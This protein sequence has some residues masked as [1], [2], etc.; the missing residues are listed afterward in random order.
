MNE[1]TDRI[2]FDPSA[3]TEQQLDGL[4]CVVCADA[5]AAGSRSV[6]AGE[7]LGAQVFACSSHVADPRDVD[8]AVSAAALDRRAVID[9]LSRVIAAL[10]GAIASGDPDRL[11]RAVAEAEPVVRRARALIAEWDARRAE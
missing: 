3:L 5:F 1:R 2:T 9:D 8:P 6:P 11:A 4:A 7:A 10:E